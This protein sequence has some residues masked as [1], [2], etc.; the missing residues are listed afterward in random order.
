MMDDRTRLIELLARY[1]IKTG[2]FTLSSGMVSNLYID[3]RATTM[4]PEG[5]MLIGQLALATLRENRWPVDAV[6]GLTLGADPIA[7]AISYTSNLVPPLIRAFTVRKEAKI[8]GTGKLIEG[9][10]QKGDRVVIVEDVITTG[11]SGLHAINAVNAAG[12]TVHGLLAIVDR[13]EGGIAMVNRA[14]YD[15]L[16]LI[17]LSE[18]TSI[19]EK[20]SEEIDFSGA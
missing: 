9:A 20:M 16:S 19:K 10:F 4:R 5:L 2:D 7:Y 17:R 13:E 15:A 3:A 12:G 11:V 18:I 6:G 14:G 1:S 8:H